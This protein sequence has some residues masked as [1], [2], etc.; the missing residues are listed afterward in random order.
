MA[1]FPTYAVSLV[2]SDAGAPPAIVTEFSKSGWEWVRADMLS[3]MPPESK[4][5]IQITNTHKVLKMFAPLKFESIIR[6]NFSPNDISPTSPGQ[7]QPRIMASLYIDSA[8]QDQ[9]EPEL[10]GINTSRDCLCMLCYNNR[11]L[12]SACS[13]CKHLE[14]WKL[15]KIANGA[16]DAPIEITLSVASTSVNNQIGTHT[17]IIAPRKLT[18]VKIHV[19]SGSEECNYWMVSQALFLYLNNAFSPLWSSYIHHFS[20]FIVPSSSQTLRCLTLHSTLS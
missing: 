9:P 11:S 4:L 10:G 20:F 17:E 16:E 14:R 19:F 5:K 2:R 1:T 3:S 18:E 7:L 15:D 6:H 12:N 8:S 13:I